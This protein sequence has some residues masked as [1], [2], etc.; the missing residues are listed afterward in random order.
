MY[1]IDVTFCLLLLLMVQICTAE[2]EYRSIKYKNCKSIFEIIDV[3]ADQ[4]PGNGN[5][6]HFIRGTQPRI[7]ITFK[8]TRDVNNFEASV[9][10]KLSAVMVPFNLEQP[11]ACQQSNIT[12]PLIAGQTY[13]YSQT[14]NILD[15]Y[16]KVSVQVN[17]LL[18][19][20]SNDGEDFANKREVCIIFLAKLIDR[21]ESITAP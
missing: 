4:C 19:D 7:R 11:D 18:N 8:P 3:E 5:V 16:P 6:C 14:V 1:S 20:K 13:Y 17:W 12:C 15:S 21:G 2:T 10:A 9:R